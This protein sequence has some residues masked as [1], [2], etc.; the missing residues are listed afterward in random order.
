VVGKE[1]PETSARGPGPPAAGVLGAMRRSLHHSAFTRPGHRVS[2]PLFL[3]K[4]RPH[5]D[6]DA[7]ATAEMRQYWN[8]FRG[9]QTTH[10][11]RARAPRPLRRSRQAASRCRS[12]ASKSVAS[13]S[14]GDGD[15]PSSDDLDHRT[16]QLAPT[17]AAGGTSTHRTERMPGADL[18]RSAL[19]PPI[20]SDPR[21]PWPLSARPGEAYPW[22]DDRSTPP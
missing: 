20:C 8:A 11:P 9:R 5:R 18:A 3:R 12:Q 10:G 19:R 21:L 7:L 1:S 17:G 22:A 14:G 2:L 4:G 16:G 6:P 13:S 15:G